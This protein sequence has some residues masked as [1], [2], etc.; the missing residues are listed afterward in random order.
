VISSDEMSKKSD[1]KMSTRRGKK[2]FGKDFEST[3]RFSLVVSVTVINRLILVWMVMH[4]GFFEPPSCDV[5]VFYS[6]SELGRQYIM[7]N[8]FSKGSAEALKLCQ[9]CSRIAFH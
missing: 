6:N 9:N 5:H 7:L 2:L 1:S 4:M 3:K 8:S